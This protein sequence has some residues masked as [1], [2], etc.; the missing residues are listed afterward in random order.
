MTRIMDYP[1]EL[2]C[3]G[4]VEGTSS[5]RITDNKGKN[6]GT[7]KSQIED[8]YSLLSTTNQEIRT[9]SNESYYKS[10]EIF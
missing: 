5:S 2:G 1:S 7:H 10:T 3:G 6:R 4:R 8:E 9:Q